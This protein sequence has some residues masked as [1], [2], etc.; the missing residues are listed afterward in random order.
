MK[1]EKHD[2]PISISISISNLYLY[3]LISIYHINQENKHGKQNIYR[4]Q[5]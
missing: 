2:I 3:L 5:Y 1:D 4:P